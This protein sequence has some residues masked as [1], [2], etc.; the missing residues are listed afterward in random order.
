LISMVCGIRL[1]AGRKI[2]S[3]FI[4][5]SWGASLP[6]LLL[7]PFI[8]AVFAIRSVQRNR[9]RAAWRN[10][11]QGAQDRFHA[12]RLHGYWL[13]RTSIVRATS[14][15]APAV[16]PV[17]TAVYV[18]GGTGTLR[19]IRPPL[20][21]GLASTRTMVFDGCELGTNATEG[22]IHRG[23]TVFPAGPPVTLQLRFTKPLN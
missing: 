23:N 19:L 5:I 2:S 7:C 21:T 9:L 16:L 3:G 10:V 4:T 13:A 17:M 22:T 11:G 6:G 8:G 15:I 12:P 20:G 18:P 1:D 14:C